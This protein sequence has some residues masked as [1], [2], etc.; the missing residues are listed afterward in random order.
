MRLVN[1]KFLLAKVICHPSVGIESCSAAAVDLQLTLK[2][3]QGGEWGTLCSREISV[4]GLSVQ[5]SYSI[6]SDSLR[7]HGL[8]QARLPCP[9]LTPRAYS[10]SCPSSW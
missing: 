6:V 2:G 8:Q 7:P 4:T 10:D 9:S 3:A 5:F 1:Y